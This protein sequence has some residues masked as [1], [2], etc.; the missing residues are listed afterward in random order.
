MPSPIKAPSPLARN[1]WSGITFFTT[2]LLGYDWITCCLL[3]QIDSRATG[4]GSSR[5]QPRGL[6][7]SM[8]DVGL[9]TL[10]THEV[11]TPLPYCG[12]WSVTCHHHLTIFFQWFT[13][14]VYYQL[15][16]V[17]CEKDLEQSWRDLILT[18]ICSL[19]HQ[20][21]CLEILISV[22]TTSWEFQLSKEW[23]LMKGKS[24]Q[25]HT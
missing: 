1:A 13:N 6:G 7:S 16:A 3:S 24:R 19:H 23:Q 9:R 22:A 14:R 17:I 11:Q 4:S 25:K 5:N 21:I 18:I 10:Q 2:T 20:T 15:L 12:A 8:S